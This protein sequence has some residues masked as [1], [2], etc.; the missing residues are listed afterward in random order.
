MKA[1]DIK[2]L[3]TYL[4]NKDLANIFHIHND[5]DVVDG[6]ISVFNIMRTVY[7]L[8][9][10][11]IP[12]SYFKYYNIQ[13]NDTWNLI[14]HKLYGTIELWWILLKF[15]SIKDPTFDPVHNT[16]IRYVPIETVSNILNDITNL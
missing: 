6:D 3:E 5:F 7:L 1:N 2:E 10:D 15:N 8:N 4:S 12:L 16:T 11:E 14:S 9:L 13:L